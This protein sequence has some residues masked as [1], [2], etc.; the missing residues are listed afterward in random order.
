MDN[1]RDTH[2]GYL[3]LAVELAREH[4]QAGAGGPFGA[5]IV[6]D[7][8]VI[9]RGWNRVTSDHD[10]TAHAEISAIRD[11]CR[12]SGDF[13]LAGSV[14]YTTCEPCPM[15]LGAIWWARIETIYFASDR[16][17][18]ARIGFD[19][20]ALYREV[21]LALPDR[22]LPLIQHRIAAADQLMAD[23]LK[24]EDKIPY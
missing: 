19:D 21:S 22:Q 9:G 8:T 6:R 15:C 5:V 4:M 3:H 11:A 7:G 2:E 12:T 20:A 10:P 17:D 18:A 23:W 1:T 13:S 24:K 14:I 16:G